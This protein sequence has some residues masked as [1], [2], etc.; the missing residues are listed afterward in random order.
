MHFSNQLFFSKMTALF[1]KRSLDR[2]FVFNNL[3][4]LFLFGLFVPYRHE[5]IDRVVTRKAWQI[6]LLIPLHSSSG[7]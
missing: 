3:T 7:H 4:A 5:A 6:A 1:Y 2:S